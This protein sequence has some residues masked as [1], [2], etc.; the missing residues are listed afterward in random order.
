MIR[1]LQIGNYNFK[2]IFKI[3]KDVIW[4]FHKNIPKQFESEYDV[5]IL[6]KN[7]TWKEAHVLQ[8]E[9]KAYTLFF[10]NKIFDNEP[11][12]YL[13]KTKFAKRIHRSDIEYFLNEKVKLFFSDP[14]GEKY[15]FEN[16]QVNTNF[17]GRI[18]QKGHCYLQLIGN[19]GIDYS[20]IALW[21]NN[22]PIEK[23]Q[24]LEFWLE[25]DK[26]K[27]VNIALKIVQFKNGTVSEKQ[28]SW[29]FN[30]EDM[31]NLIYIEN[32]YSK[33]YLNVSLL[34]KGKGDLKIV[35]LHDR[36][37]RKDVGEFL[38]GGIREV[39]SKRQEVFFYFDP[40]N[41]KPPLNVYFSGYKTREG[42]EGYHLLRSLGCP[43]LLIS[44]ARLEGGEMYVGSKEY[45]EIIT[46][47]IKEYMK[48]L[49]FSCD[50]VILSGLS[51]G[52]YGALYYSCD[53]HPYAVIA[54]KP[55][56]N[57]GDI[58]ANARLIRPSEFATSLDF[59]LD[60]Y[61]DLSKD[62]ID[63]FNNR[64][65]TKFNGTKWNQTIFAIS[66]MLEDDYDQ[67]AYKN[68]LDN[69]KD[70][71]LQ[72][73]GKGIHGRHNDNTPEIVA[74]FVDQYKRILEEKFGRSFNSQ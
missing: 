60:Y 7:I 20:Q 32:K 30:E 50:E 33:A 67:K 31:Q 23:N 62:S 22:I 71:N 72:I 19:F 35:A 3:P 24:T 6:D 29:I 34:A 57:V 38:P 47:K 11:A 13:E 63:S 53:I 55:L 40:G 21:I 52:T 27:D 10:T 9:I 5:T 66:Y 16:L 65:W 39:S 74:W 54:G 69:F 46:R 41:L 61:G 42:F 48:C 37:S 59:L 1:V 15:H 8:K 64:F 28:D 25:Y 26:S 56:L 2:K 58:A 70:S 49:N 68:L 73:Y 43:F 51:M 36:H 17:K 4:N 45:E 44:D 12:S 14:Y 18:Y